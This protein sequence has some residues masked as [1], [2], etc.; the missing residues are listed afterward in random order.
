MMIVC[1][2]P[3]ISVLGEDWFRCRAAFAAMKFGIIPYW[4]ARS[5]GE[6]LS[7]DK[8]G[9]GGCRL[10]L[11]QSGGCLD[12]NWLV[13]F[14]ALPEITGNADMNCPEERLYASAKYTSEGF[15]P[16]WRPAAYGVLGSR[17]PKFLRSGRQKA[18][19][20]RRLSGRAACRCLTRSKPLIPRGN[21]APYFPSQLLRKS[22]LRR[23][24]RATMSARRTLHCGPG[25]LTLTPERVSNVQQNAHRRVASRRNPGGRRSW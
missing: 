24:S 22:A 14:P 21:A 10:G 4:I 19:N 20:R 16:V 18:R 3:E 8:A 25:P 1:L 5:S 7:K 6:G 17:I 13:S 9:S 11:D 2:G 23:S 12:N 15:A